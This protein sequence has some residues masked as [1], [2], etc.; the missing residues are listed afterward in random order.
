MLEVADALCKTHLRQK[1]YAYI[2]GIKQV[3]DIIK[4]IPLEQSLLEEGWGIYHQYSDQDWGLTN[5]ISFVV[6]RLEGITE[7]LTYD[8]HFQQAGFTKFNVVNIFISEK[9]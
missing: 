7:A 2:N 9:N 8:R 5:C 3:P 1:I 6:I 4:I